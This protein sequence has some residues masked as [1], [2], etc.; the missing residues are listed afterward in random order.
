MKNLSVVRSSVVVKLS[1]LGT[2]QVPLQEQIKA[3]VSVAP[4]LVLDIDGVPFNSMML[5][6][7][8]NV[9]MA[10]AERWSGRPF[11]VALIR[12]P[13]VTKQI[14]RIAKLA[15][16]LPLYDDL[17][18]AWRAFGSTPGQARASS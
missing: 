12:A 16:K 6:E 17:E 5:G 13:E 14:I 8:V 4:Y 2:S 18:S 10:Y 9:Y 11:G 15:D 3:I 1:D 7:L